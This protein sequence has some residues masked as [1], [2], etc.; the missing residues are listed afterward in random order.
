ML[1]PALVAC[2][3]SPPSE[4]LAIHLWNLRN[5]LEAAERGIIQGIRKRCSEELKLQQEAG[6]GSSEATQHLKVS[7]CHENSKES[8]RP[9]K[10]NFPIIGGSKDDMVENI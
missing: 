8:S 5:N 7:I 2:C 1:L 10:F 3:P 4:H 9:P 6:S